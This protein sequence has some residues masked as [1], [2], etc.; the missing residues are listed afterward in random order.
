MVARR[1]PNHLKGDRNMSMFIYH[2]EL[3][4]D[5]N[6]QGLSPSERKRLDKANFLRMAI[7]EDGLAHKEDK[8]GKELEEK[9]RILIRLL[10]APS[11]GAIHKVAKDAL[12]LLEEYRPAGS[13]KTKKILKG[14]TEIQ[15]D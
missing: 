12:K 2:S 4:F 5:N 15:L 13:E 11:E 8:P 6:T 9:L 7:L 14:L 10:Y 3:L 1:K